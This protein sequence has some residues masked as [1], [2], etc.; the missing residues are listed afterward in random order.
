MAK[1]D[2][3]VYIDTRIDTGGFGK[4]MSDVKHKVSAVS[5]SVNKLGNSIKNSLSEASTVN[6]GK[7]Y[8]ELRKEIAKTEIQLDKLIEKQI[9]FTETGGNIKSRAFAGMEYD[10]EQTRN[11]LFGLREQLK[12]TSAETPQTFNNMQKWTDRVRNAFNKLNK[13]TKK[14]HYSIMR[15]LGTSLL[16]STVFRAISTITKGFG[17]GINN[18][19][20]YSTETNAALSA[21]KSSLTQLKNSFA[22]AFAP[23]L[24]VVTPA[25]TKFINLIIKAN[26]YVSSLF[27]ALAGKNTYTKAVE[28][29]EDYAASLNKTAKSAKEAKK[30]LS[31][32]DEIRTFTENDSINGVSSRDMFKETQIEEATVNLAEK[33]RNAFEEGDWQF[34]GET[35]GKKL[36]EIK[37]KEAFIKVGNFVENMV[38]DAIEI[39][40]GSYSADPI[41]TVI[42]SALAAY[43]LI[44][45]I[46][47]NPTIAIGVIT[48]KLGFEAGKSLG[49]L[50]F[51]EDKELYENFSFFGENGFFD[52]LKNTDFEN[53]LDAWDDM[54]ADI[55]NSPLYRFLTNTW[56]LPKHKTDDEL[57]AEW[58]QLVHDLNVIGE[59]IVTFGE[60]YIVKPFKM[61]GEDIADWWHEDVTPWFTKDK[62]VEAMKGIKDAFNTTWKGAVNTAIELLNKFIDFINE[63]MHFEWDAFKVMGKELVPA[64]NVQLFTIPKIPYLAKGAVIPPNAP[65]M[66]MLGDQKH[67]TNI[68][69]PLDTIKQAV[70]EVIGGNNGTTQYAFTAQINRRTLFEEMIDE[71]KLRQS[72]SGRNPF[73]LA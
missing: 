24:T 42:A 47:I 58:E 26:N 53:M 69:A 66:A 32:L 44:H 38:D 72:T 71:A 67:G 63:K 7:N 68:E 59:G 39:W 45:T 56:V 19:A 30:Y 18:L 3:T 50:L 27:S 35:I 64:G 15:M 12:L 5:N 48:W 13:T 49:K 62:W 8:D 41:G 21:L 70:R 55:I 2:G 73:D 31:G 9:R 22:T 54:Y 23:I 37:W 43:F 36:K 17:E 52:I 1:S 6:A 11:K 51:P 14:S 4:G 28:V 34:I 40:K 65:F 60:D 46:G 29:Q 20:G 25:I 10:I 57:K 16:F 61:W 33:L